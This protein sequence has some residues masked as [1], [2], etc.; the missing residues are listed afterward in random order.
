[1]CKMRTV[2]ILDQCGDF[3]PNFLVLLKITV[4]QQIPLGDYA[5]QYDEVGNLYLFSEYQGNKQF[6]RI[7][8]PDY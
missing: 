8:F 1:M 7:Y 3:L 6:C 2:S 5:T 4:K